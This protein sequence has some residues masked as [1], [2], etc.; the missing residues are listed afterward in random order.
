[1]EEKLNEIYGKIAETL[2]E[3]IPEEW[4]K[5]YVYGE[6]L[7]DVQKGFF[8]YYP[9]SSNLSVY[10]HDIPNLFEVSKDEYRKM[11]NQLLEDLEE[12]WC[13]FKN[14]GQEQ[15]TN[16]TFILENNGKFK[17]DYDYTDLSDADDSERHLIWNYKY[18]GIMPEDEDDKQIVEEYI[19]TQE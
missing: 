4:D 14:N 8:N 5:V 12:L 6:I 16:L 9:K 17:I 18:L 3:T 2:N 10:S 19:K 13:E 11:W 15:W 7:E 1:M